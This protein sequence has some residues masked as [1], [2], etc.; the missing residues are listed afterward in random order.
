MENKQ[1]KV[2]ILGIDLILKYKENP[3]YLQEIVNYF[4]NKIDEIR[5][6]RITNDPLKI[7]IMAGL[8][9]TAEI[10]KNQNKSENTFDVEQSPIDLSLITQRMIKKIDK[11]L[12]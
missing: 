7:S 10:I 4:K 12:T 6:N 8:D 11:G 9:I 3:E 2:N 1:L 5:E